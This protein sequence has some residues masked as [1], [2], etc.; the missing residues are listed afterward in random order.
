M[1]NYIISN[2]KLCGIAQ[3]TIDSETLI[4]KDCLFCRRRESAQIQMSEIAD[5]AGAITGFVQATLSNK[6]LQVKALL[7]AAS[8]LITS[9]KLNQEQMKM[10]LNCCIYE[11]ENL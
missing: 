9:N 2:C 5:L 3:G 7:Y 8:A 11:F 10:F 4:C 6:E 1:S